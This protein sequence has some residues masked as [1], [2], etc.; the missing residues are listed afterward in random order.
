MIVI[1]LTGGIGSGKS[2]VAAMLAERGA[3][4]IDA[5][6]IVRELQA[7][8]TPLVL[9]IAERFGP[10]VITADGSLNRQ[11]VADIVFNDSSALE[12]LNA[13][14]HPAVG[15][16]TLA[17]IAAA[18]EAD[19]DAVIVL[20]VPLLTEKRRADTQ[21]VIVVDVAEDVAVSRL[22][23]FRNFSETDA[24]ARIAHQATRE[25]RRAIA[26]V[27]VDNSGDREHLETEVAR[28][29]EW[30]KRR[31]SELAGVTDTPRS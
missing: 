8:G 27:V 19:P 12:D 24:R 5:D 11:A 29:W 15:V 1:G 2:T 9:K 16:E 23:Q 13:I 10:A 14:V 18:I 28:A 30:I 21:G 31:Q 20:D 17:R 25:E 7:P 4:I 3:T 22:I 26:D 6:A